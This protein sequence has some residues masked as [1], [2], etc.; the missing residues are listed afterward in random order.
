MA[1]QI[2]QIPPGVRDKD[3]VNTIND[4][5]RQINVA[6]AGGETTAATAATINFGTHA[7]RM[8]TPVARVPS[9]SIWNE[10]DRT[11][12][13]QV[14]NN[15]WKY[16]GGMLKANFAAGPSGL[17]I[18]D[19]GLLWSVSDYA[20]IVR[21]TGTGWEFVDTP[22]RYIAFM[23]SPPDGNGWQV[24][25]GS[26]THYLAVAGGLMAEVSFTTINWIG[27]SPQVYPRFG[28]SYSG[29]PLAAIA[30]TGN[31]FVPHGTTGTDAISSIKADGQPTHA[32]LIPYFR[33]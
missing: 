3:L 31:S 30:P 2:P 17:G 19:T 21:W 8:A 5:L 28:A 20:H 14:Q 6:L 24:C 1:E 9:G 13:Y 26:A 22:G 11:V 33:R 29:G 10:T 18:A 4:R 25:D 32:D 16:T 27:A 12:S 23:T 7:A 15:Q